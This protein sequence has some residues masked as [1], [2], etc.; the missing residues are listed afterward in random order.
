M[1]RGRLGLFTVQTRRYQGVVV[2]EN[3]VYGLSA[4]VAEL[5]VTSD[6]GQVTVPTTLNGLIRGRYR[7]AVIRA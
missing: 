4:G 2:F 5:A 6:F 7:R 1:K 3:F